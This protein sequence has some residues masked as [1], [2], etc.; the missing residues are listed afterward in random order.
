[1]E[2]PYKKIME[3]GEPFLVKHVRCI[4]MPEVLSDQVRFDF[5]RME[6]KLEVAILKEYESVRMVS[7]PLCSKLFDCNSAIEVNIETKSSSPPL[8]AV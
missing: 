2:K 7:K 3:L 8:R 5:N 6:G 1:M 4:G